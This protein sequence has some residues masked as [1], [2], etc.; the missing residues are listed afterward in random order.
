[1]GVVVL[2]ILIVVEKKA[3]DDDKPFLSL[4]VLDQQKQ[5]QRCFLV[6]RFLHCLRVRFGWQQNHTH[7]HTH[8]FVS[9]RSK[10]RFSLFSNTLFRCFFNGDAHF[11]YSFFFYTFYVCLAINVCC[12]LKVFMINFPALVDQSNLMF[13]VLCHYLHCRHFIL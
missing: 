10:A 2:L 13:H 9:T 8:G 1:M 5:Q 6:L 12:L 7:T 3:K 4:P 11:Q